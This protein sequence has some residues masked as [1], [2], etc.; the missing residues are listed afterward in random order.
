MYFIQVWNCEL[1]FV[2]VVLWASLKQLHSFLPIWASASLLGI[3][4]I[5]FS[6]QRANFLLNTKAPLPS[7]GHLL[8]PLQ[9]LL[10]FSFLIKYF[11]KIQLK[12]SRALFHRF[13]RCSPI[14]EAWATQIP[15]TITVSL[16]G[17]CYSWSSRWV[18]VVW[19]GFWLYS[20]PQVSSGDWL[21]GQ[22][23]I[24]KSTDTRVP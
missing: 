20:C 9:G 23:Q 21:Q 12:C 11:I 4:S 2:V 13:I 14:S 5:F 19:R 7:L 8:L 22:P 15:V 1:L 10:F 24:P 17:T 3:C 18:L 6:S 16:P